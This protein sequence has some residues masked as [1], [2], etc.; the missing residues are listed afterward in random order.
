MR[1]LEKCPEC[2]QRFHV[3]WHLAREILSK[4]NFFDFH[5]YIELIQNKNLK[6]HYFQNDISRL[7]QSTANVDF[8]H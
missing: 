8:A 4:R 7:Q 6:T 5:Y 1:K 2:L 3:D